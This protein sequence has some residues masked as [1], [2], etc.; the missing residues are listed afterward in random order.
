MLLEPLPRHRVRG[1][2]YATRHGHD[3]LE[4]AQWC[5]YCFLQ[6]TPRLSACGVPAYGVVGQIS[7]QGRE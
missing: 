4:C 1:A 6:H 5:G 7:W 2:D 3:G